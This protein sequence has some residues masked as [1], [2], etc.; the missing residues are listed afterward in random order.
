MRATSLI[1]CRLLC[2]LFERVAL[3]LLS[4]PLCFYPCLHL[5]SLCFVQRAAAFAC[6]MFL[7][8]PHA[9]FS[10]FL[11]PF[12][13]IYTLESCPYVLPHFSNFYFHVLGR[14]FGVAPDYVCSFC[15]FFDLTFHPPTTHDF[16]RSPHPSCC[17][18]L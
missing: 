6:Q 13:A 9:W 10:M 5:P 2:F 15:M 14:N 1:L 12:C 4:V 11:L 18:M 7:I 17:A 8:D 3:P 16:S